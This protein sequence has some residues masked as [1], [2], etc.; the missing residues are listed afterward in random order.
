ME[1][2]NGK[3]VKNITEMEK[4]F[5]VK[6]SLDGMTLQ[7]ASLED[8]YWKYSRTGEKIGTIFLHL[9]LLPTR[10]EVIYEQHAGAERGYLVI[11]GLNGGVKLL[12]LPKSK[13][14]KKVFGNDASDKTFHIPDLILLDDKNKEIFMIEGEP[15]K[16][17]IGNKKGV[18]QLPLF[19][20]LEKYYLEKYYAGYTCKK[21]VVLFGDEK[22]PDIMTDDDKDKVAF[23][24]KTDGTMITYPKC[25][26]IIADAV[27][28]I[29]NS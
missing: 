4:N 18:N 1:S 6:V 15:A 2:S 20:D 5:G 19:N 22:F 17:V 28:K 8:A 26:Q 29:Q 12:D 11:P 27:N 3:L 21:F 25:P 13:K 9:I 23:R 7:Q 24:L 14:S 10:L 16:N